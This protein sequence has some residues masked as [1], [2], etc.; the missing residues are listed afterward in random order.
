MPYSPTDDMAAYNICK[1]V[2]LSHRLLWLP[3]TSQANCRYHY[4]EKVE[5][6][7][8]NLGRLNGCEHPTIEAAVVSI[9]TNK[10]LLS[11]Q[12][13]NPFSYGEG[14]TG[15]GYAIQDLLKQSENLKQSEK[16]VPE[17]EGEVPKVLN[18]REV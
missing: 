9:A 13:K 16:L 15:R 2:L 1:G 3:L 18:A 17:A 6:I 5:I 14:S 12:H 8:R 10:T 4:K 11:A 7:T